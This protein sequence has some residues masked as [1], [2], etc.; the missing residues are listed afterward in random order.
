MREL[1][2]FAWGN[3]FAALAV[4]AEELAIGGIVGLAVCDELEYVCREFLLDLRA[5]NIHLPDAAPWGPALA[6]VAAVADQLGEA[7]PAVAVGTWRYLI[8]GVAADD[9]VDD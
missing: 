9:A 2:H 7:V 6:V 5:V 3:V 8:G 4:A 1:V